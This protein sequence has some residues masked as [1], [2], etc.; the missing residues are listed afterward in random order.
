[1]HDPL[2]DRVRAKGGEDGTLADQI[3]VKQ[4]FFL[5]KLSFSEEKLFYINMIWLDFHI[6][7]CQEG[8]KMSRSVPDEMRNSLR[9]STTDV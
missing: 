7:S 2:R 8:G 9:R 6:V 5:Q 3:V 1:M 4:Y